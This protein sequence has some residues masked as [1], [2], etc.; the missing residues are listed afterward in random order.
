MSA[1]AGRQAVNS[2][3][4]T[5]NAAQLAGYEY[6]DAEY[7][8]LGIR[9]AKGDEIARGIMEDIQRHT[10]I[11]VAAA[12]EAW[13]YGKPAEDKPGPPL[14]RRSNVVPFRPRTSAPHPP[15][16]DPAA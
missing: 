1:P 8:R 15:E 5:Q 12:R 7:L 10:A 3:E 13:G 11:R 6:D 9:A 2:N 16:P 4:K 14:I